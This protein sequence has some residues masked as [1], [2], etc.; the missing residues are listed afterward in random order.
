MLGAHR[1]RVSRGWMFRIILHASSSES[2]LD[3]S[4]A[5]LGG[6]NRRHQLV[7]ITSRGPPVCFRSR[8]GYVPKPVPQITSVEASAWPVRW[9]SEPA[10]AEGQGAD[11]CSRLQENA[12]DGEFRGEGGG[13]STLQDFRHIVKARTQA[14]VIGPPNF[15]AHDKGQLN[16]R[17]VLNTH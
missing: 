10:S 6:G 12:H 1:A 4:P 9:L 15:L 17:D 8:Q 3:R 2:D 16:S 14:V 13:G 5:A 7:T 11:P